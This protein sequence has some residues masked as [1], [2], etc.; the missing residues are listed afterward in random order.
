MDDDLCLRALIVSLHGGRSHAI[1][2]RLYDDGA[3]LEVKGCL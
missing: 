1:P 2:L 3:Y